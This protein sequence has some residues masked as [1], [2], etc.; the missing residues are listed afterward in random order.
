MK[1]TG[2]KL[3]RPV[4]IH[5]SVDNFDPD[6]TKLLTVLI[7]TGWADRII[8]DA[9]ALQR[10]ASASCVNNTNTHKEVKA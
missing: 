3:D 1:H 7:R 10:Q 5:G 6:R 9:L 8:D 4:V 2:K